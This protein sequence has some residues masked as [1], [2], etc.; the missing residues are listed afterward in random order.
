VALITAVVGVVLV[1][2]VVIANRRV[3]HAGAAARA[4]FQSGAAVAGIGHRQ[5]AV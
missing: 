4:W 5:E 3:W 2:L 1:V